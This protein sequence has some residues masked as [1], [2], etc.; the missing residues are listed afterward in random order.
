[1]RSATC[2]GVLCLSFDQHGH[3]K[4]VTLTT[5]RPWVVE[6]G[7]EPVP[8]QLVSAEGGGVYKPRQSAQILLSLWIYRTT[9]G[10]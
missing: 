2:W 1:M 9:E 6:D 5:V 4:F 8:P 7:P 10:V 3:P